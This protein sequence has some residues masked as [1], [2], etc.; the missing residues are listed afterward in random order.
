M[1][2]I[3]EILD[4]KTTKI[5]HATINFKLARK[6]AIKFCAGIFC[7]QS[8]LDKKVNLISANKLTISSPAS[9]KASS[10]FQKLIYQY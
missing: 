6:K 10:L 9:A 5:L 1:D 7:F 2:E 3:A 8:F 4:T